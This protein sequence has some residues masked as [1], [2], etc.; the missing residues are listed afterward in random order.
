MKMDFAR[1]IYEVVHVDRLAGFIS[2][3]DEKGEKIE[4]RIAI[5][6]NKELIT[7]IKEG[8]KLE[9]EVNGWQVKS[10][11]RINPEENMAHI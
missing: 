2:V 4:I 8:D 10:I 7:K 6:D 9:V 5:K 11:K 1:V 3:K